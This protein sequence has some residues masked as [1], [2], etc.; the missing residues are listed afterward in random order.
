MLVTFY[1]LMTHVPSLNSYFTGTT[2]IGIHAVKKIWRL[3]SRN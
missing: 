1:F 3:L 2:A